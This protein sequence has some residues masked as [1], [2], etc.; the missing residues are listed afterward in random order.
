MSR[1]ESSAR[2][3]M[4]KAMQTLAV[5]PKAT[6]K[7]ALERAG[8]AESTALS[9]SVQNTKTWKVLREEY[10]P[11]ELIAK[12]HKN[13]L[14]ARK[15]AHHIFPKDEDEAVIREVIE[16]I[17]GARIISFSKDVSGKVC[18]FTVPDTLAQSKALDMAHKVAGTYAA[19]K[20]RHE[21]NEFE[22]MSD[23]ELMEIV[24]GNEHLLKRYA[25]F[26]DKNESAQDV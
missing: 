24:K 2:R 4:D 17:P 22:Q 16:S 20:I 7:G 26:I 5:D 9:S 6:Q 25:S 14:E 18:Y 10:F 11:D 19:T 8:Y 3:K 23:E 15:I 12:T 1:K 13:L 21:F